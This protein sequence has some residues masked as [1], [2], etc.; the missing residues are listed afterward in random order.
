MTPDRG[1]CSIRGIAREYC[2]RPARHTPTRWWRWS[3]R[4]P[5]PTA[6]AGRRGVNDEAPIRA[7]W[8]A[9]VTSRGSCVASTSA[10]PR[11]VDEDPLTEAGM[12]PISLAVDVTN[13]VM[14]GLGQPLHA[15][16][17][18]RLGNRSSCAG[19]APGSG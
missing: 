18:A 11:R 14:L 10:P 8:A 12:R 13:Y 17:L 6:V 16:D 5:R 9:R 3:P 19:R 4:R 1:Y 2:T 15:F 7:E